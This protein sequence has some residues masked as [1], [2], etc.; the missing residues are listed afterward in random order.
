MEEFKRTETRYILKHVSGKYFRNSVFAT[1]YDAFLT[2]DI[3]QAT[4]FTTKE[5]ADAVV[6]RNKKAK[7][8]Y[9]GEFMLSTTLMDCSVVVLELNIEGKLYE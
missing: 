4:R 6:K 2:D 3:M 9:A 8:K 1:S 5:I 7:F